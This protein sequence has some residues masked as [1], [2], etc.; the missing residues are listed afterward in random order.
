MKGM[1]FRCFPY[2]RQIANVI[3]VQQKLLETPGVTQDVV[4][5]AGQRAVTF[6]NVFHL[7]VTPFKNRNAAEHGTLTILFFTVFAYHV[8]TAPYIISITADKNQPTNKRDG[9]TNGRA[10]APLFAHTFHPMTEGRNA[11]TISH[12]PCLASA[13]NHTRVT[14][15]LCFEI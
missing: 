5:N 8:K 3:R 4:G 12:T 6:V 14:L 1:E 2:L 13:L 15:G 11:R 9:R 7:P 10:L